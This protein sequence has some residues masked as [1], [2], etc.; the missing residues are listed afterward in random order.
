MLR[1]ILSILAF[2][3]LTA[4]G[5][6]PKWAPDEAVADAVYIHD[7]PPTLTL[8]TV[9]S[10]RSGSG[11]HAALMVN[12]SQRVLFDPAGTWHHPNLPERNDVH[13]GITD[14]AVEFYL[15][16]HSRVT[17]HTIRQDLVVSPEVAEMAL[18]AVQEYGAVPKA[19]C[20]RSVSSILR[21][22]PHPGFEALPQTLFPKA[23]ADAFRE[24]PGIT[25][26][27]YF[28]DDPEEN[29]YILTNNI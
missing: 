2:A 13:F 29:G 27:T 7:G 23:L 10:N 4:C 5:A 12:G 26:D 19:M 21:S 17:Y 28:D 25:E 20:T 3:A 8:F 9:V 6:E 14:A 22:L 11:A 1:I 15:D 16:Y 18:R 24:V